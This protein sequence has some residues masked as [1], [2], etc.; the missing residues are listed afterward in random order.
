[1]GA[2]GKGDLIVPIAT[3][4]IGIVAG[5]I[6]LVV[7]IL[8]GASLL[9]AAF[10]YCLVGA[11]MIFLFAGWR[12]ASQDAASVSTTRPVDYLNPA[13]S[14]SDA[15]PT[16]PL[17]QKE[18]MRIL[19]VDDDSFVLELIPKIAA[20]AGSTDVSTVTSGEEALAMLE[21]ATVPFDC[22]LLDIKMPEMDGIELC[23]RIRAMA[24]YRDTPIIMLT[25]M[26]DLDY[27][28][29][30]L[31]AGASDYTSK[32]FDVI[33]FAE[34]LQI[35]RAWTMARR[36]GASGADA[37]DVEMLD[38]LDD[39][40]FTP[41]AAVEGLVQYEALHNYLTQFR[42]SALTNAYVMA[43]MVEQINDVDKGGQ[44]APPSK[45]LT[46]VALE[47]E[48]VF[49]HSSYAMAYAGQG[50]FV[51]VANAA[52]PPIPAAIEARLRQLLSQANGENEAS[53]SPIAS[54]SVGLAVRPGSSRVRRAKIAFETAISL[55][56]GRVEA[57][58]ATRQSSMT[59]RL[60][61]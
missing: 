46:R 48:K 8:F 22:F 31:R 24:D 7:A 36:A 57:K 38:A 9:V 58:Q 14:R 15:G 40:Q 28:D 32:P 27:L 5:F 53:L 6:G 17:V 12:A 33:E 47:I 42:G 26:T 37:A 18:S 4:M 23:T 50:Q 41:S 49:N 29:R 45:V 61:R 2:C 10:A 43:I 54:I 44:I 25:A 13:K 11:A 51:V 1:M 55:A 3:A 21:N 60:R 52:T 19:A 30:A 16:T 20:N 34:R 59:G 35:A 56:V 39:A